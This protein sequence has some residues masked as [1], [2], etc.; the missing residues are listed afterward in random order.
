MKGNRF[1]VLG[2]AAIAAAIVFSAPAHAQHNPETDFRFERTQDGSG[3][4]ITGFVGR[5]TTV[6]IPPEIRG[7]PVV[8]I[9]VDAFHGMR[10]ISVVI[11]DS[12]TFIGY[13]AFSTNQLTGITIPG[14]VI[15]IGESAFSNNRLTSVTILNG[16]TSIGQNAFL[17]NQ[18]T[19]ATIPDSVTSI[20]GSAFQ[21]NR[22]TNVTIPDSVT[23]IGGLA[24]NGNPLTSVTLG[25]NVNLGHGSFPGN[26]NAAYQR[27]NRRAGTY[28]LIG[29][30]W[31]EE[32]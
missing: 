22:L 28:V 14:S 29:G 30:N 4:V 3:V 19:S 25:G 31:D 16:V 26:F 10:L 18:L 6:S 13:S 2:I 24:F 23:S 8:G 9:G 20:E 1:K 7:L 17:G 21:N 32:W 5:G 15:F 27:L 11:P 12:V